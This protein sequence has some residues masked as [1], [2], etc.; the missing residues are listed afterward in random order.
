[1]SIYAILH[2]PDA[3]LPESDSELIREL[4]SGYRGQLADAESLALHAARMG[5]IDA[6]KAKRVLADIGRAR[7]VILRA[8]SR[9]IH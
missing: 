6:H 2:A 8:E 3:P 1:M 7:S 4:T 5:Y 9:F